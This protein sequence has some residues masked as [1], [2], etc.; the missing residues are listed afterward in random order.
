LTVLD[1]GQK[2]ATHYGEIRT[3]LE[4]AGTPIGVNDLHIAGQARSE[5]QSFENN[6]P[7]FVRHIDLFSFFNCS[8]FKAPNQN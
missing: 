8:F 5:G 3:D 6:V 4:R 2:A 7:F 1:Y